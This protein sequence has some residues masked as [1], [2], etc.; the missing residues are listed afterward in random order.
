MRERRP[1]PD[2]GFRIYR[3][4]DT[5]DVCVVFGVSAER[6]DGVLV[7]WSLSLEAAPALLTVT[8][9]V[10]LT[11][12]ENTREVF[13]REV[14]STDVAEIVRAIYTLTSEVCAERSWTSADSA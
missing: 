10:E 3:M 6:T 5:E 14:S 8:G 9:R 13:S 1:L 4:P 11:T 12:G 2:I 7:G